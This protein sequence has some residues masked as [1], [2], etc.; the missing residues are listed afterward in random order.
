MNLPLDLG[1]DLERGKLEHKMHLGKSKKFAVLEV[2]LRL[3]V[4]L[5]DLSKSGTRTTRI[6]RIRTVL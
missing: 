2:F 5:K 1:L 6:A 4:N 3:C